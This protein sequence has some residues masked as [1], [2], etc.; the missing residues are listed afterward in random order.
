MNNFLLIGLLVALSIV[1]LYNPVIEGRLVENII[2][3]DNKEDFIIKK[4]VENTTEEPYHAHTDFKVFING[5]E[6]DFGKPKYNVQDRLAH[7]HI[8]NDYGGYVIHLHNRN[9]TMG[10]FF[11]S[12]GMHF[13]STCFI[14]ETYNFCNNEESKLQFLVNG[15]ENSEFGDYRPNNLDRIL[16]SYNKGNIDATKE[17]ESVTDVACAFSHL[18]PIPSELVG[19]QLF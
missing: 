4:K 8:T 2:I 7:L 16:I 18:C 11:N 1:I 9:A 19:Q 14:T 15:I 12:L 3:E 5:N 6:L 13:N 10:Q 17:A